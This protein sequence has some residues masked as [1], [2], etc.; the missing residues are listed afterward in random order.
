VYIDVNE[1]RIGI[2]CCKTW[3]CADIT[4]E[5]DYDMGWNDLKFEFL[6]GER[7]FYVIYDVY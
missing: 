6:A 5:S 1:K 3:P 2:T 7:D 4:Q